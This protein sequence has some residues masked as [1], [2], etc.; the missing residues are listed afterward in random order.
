VTANAQPSLVRLELCLTRQFEGT[1]ETAI[2]AVLRG[3][4][5]LL[6]LLHAL[7]CNV[8]VEQRSGV[9]TNDRE[10][11]LTLHH[12]TSQHDAVRT[13]GENQRDTQLREVVADLVPNL[14]V[15]FQL[16]QLCLSQTRTLGNGR[17]RDEA[18]EAVLV[19]GT[20]ALKGVAVT[21][22]RI[23]VAHLGVQHTVHGL[24]VRHQTNANTRA[25]CHVGCRDVGAA[26]SPVHLGEHGSIDVR[27]EF[28]GTV[29][30]VECA[31]YVVVLKGE[32]GR[33]GDVAVGLTA[34]VQIE[35]AEAADAQCI[36]LAWSQPSA[37]E[38]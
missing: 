9:A 11:R 23:V 32:L 12:T 25:D 38:G 17:G 18:L 8:A 26:V 13:D 4:N 21:S 20:H 22:L 34:R 29:E 7:V 24:S 27:V 16:G 31:E 30:L 35:G 5:E 37:I 1:H 28:F 19:E 36:E 33:R 3:H 14:V 10:Q 15:I 6:N 2:V